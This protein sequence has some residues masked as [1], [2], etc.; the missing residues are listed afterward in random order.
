MPTRLSLAER[1]IAHTGRDE[2]VAELADTI[3]TALI[4]AIV[5]KGSA[6]FAV[7][8]GST[9]KP[10]YQALAGRDL[11]WS[12]VTVILV[13]ERWVDPGE[14]GSNESFVRDSLMRDKAAAA[15]F[16]G[17]KTSTASPQEA[18]QALNADLP[19]DLFPLD[20]AVL[21]MGA[22]GHTA[23]WFP[24]ADGLD[25]ALEA[26]APPLAA[27]TAK[28]SAVT[29]DHL[30]RMTLTL[31]VLEGARLSLLMLTG[32]EKQRT[33]DVARADGA[34]RDM[35]VR[36]LLRSGAANLQVHWAL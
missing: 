11:D 21:G 9:P 3:E 24:G 6:S 19:A 17:L 10:L 26:S 8:G 20:V 22:D 18:A 27:I 4:A 13:D 2:M 23:S 32:S 7:S 5:A 31:P 34:V 33:L 36:A 14:A 1:T 29:G 25:A 28:R 12:K 16:I 35:P 15:R 30:L